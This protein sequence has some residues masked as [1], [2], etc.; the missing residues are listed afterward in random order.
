MNRMGLR[1][2]YV[3]FFTFTTNRSAQGE[4]HVSVWTDK[5]PKLLTVPHGWQAHEGGRLYCHGYGP[6][7][8]YFHVQHGAVII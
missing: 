4:V 6:H 1:M 8:C 3:V 5:A 2:G 7:I